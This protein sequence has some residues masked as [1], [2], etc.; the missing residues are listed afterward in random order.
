MRWTT[1]LRLRLRSIFR[2]GRVEDEL[3]EELE[4]HL[5]RL[6]DDYVAGG[7]TPAEARRAARREM[8]G[9]EQRKEECRDARGLTFVNA[10]RQDVAYAL[11]TFR[12]TPAFTAVA[13]LSLALGIGAN[14][15]IFALWNGILHASL[16]AVHEPGELVML[17]NPDDQGGWTGSLEGP[18]S[19][20]TYQEFEELR[21]NAG[22]FSAMMA[23]QST[24]SDWQVRFEGGAPEETL[25]RLVSGEYF[26]VL[27][28]QPAIGRFFTASDDRAAMPYAVISHSYW[29]R[30]FGGRAD[31]IGTSFTLRK[32]SLT[33]V[34][35]APHGFIGETIGQYPDVWLPMRMQPIVLPGRDRLRDTPPEKSMWLQVFGRLK[36]GVS[37]PQAEAQANAV[38]QAH[39]ESFYGA[40]LNERRRELLDQRLV[41]RSGTQGASSTR[42]EFSLSLTALL[43]AVGLL[44]LIACANLANLLLARGTA[45][46]SEMALRLSLGASRGRLIRQLVTESMVL[47]VAGGAA[48]IL[49]AYVAHGALVR[50]I[51]ESDSDFRMTFALDPVM[52]AFVVAVTLGAAL[53]FGILPAWQ[54]TGSDPAAGLKEQTR[55]AVGTRRQMRSGR[56]LVSL[57]LALSLPLLVGAGLLARTVYNLQHAD[58]GF[59]TDNLLVVRVDV[60]EGAGRVG[61]LRELVEAIR[62]TPGVSAVSFSQLGMFTGGE[63]LATIAVEGFTPR[64]EE[65]RDSA[66]EIIGPKYF[67]TLGVPITLGRE[68]V[69]RDLGGGAPVCVINE[70]FAKR[71]FDRRNPIG[72]R[73]TPV[74]EE[75]RRS[76]QVVGVAKNARTQSLRED[77]EPR[78]FTPAQ[79]PW[80]STSSP[81][82]L[83]RTASEGSRRIEDVRRAILG[84]NGS[85]SMMSARSMDD[86]MAPST[87]QDR[88]TAW[89]AIAFGAVA[90][91]LA[92]FGLYGVLSYGVARRTAEIA[93]RIALG[94]QPARVISMILGE[95]VGLVAVGLVAGGALAY[96]TTRLIGSRLY[97]IAAQDPSTLAV[98]T[99]L[100]LLVALTATYL[101]ARRASRVD[102]LVALRQ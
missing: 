46:R 73:I 3:A 86:Q 31:M 91:L 68:I 2:F 40:A 4:Y 13:V 59:P 77:V 49:V 90:L 33:I 43:A 29:Q 88:T 15:A 6:V 93:V 11:R 83:I 28:V 30:R 78:Y 57:Q 89:L 38:F 102:P 18:R 70:A 87:A 26:Q 10:T 19:W 48:A 95:I 27:G 44:L 56:L 8:G 54:A 55:S 101:P 96:L 81:T 21:D 65:D 9:V 79:E 69:E 32:A 92:A 99:A 7:M 37:W 63:S 100:L 66:T 75:D 80:S 97:G 85:L 35:V 72:L 53:A 36:R 42:H 12:R 50:M 5:E 16:P 34:G 52:L 25:G 45:R 71:F 14:T 23:S 41:L 58:L 64:G 82:F 22:H 39:L 1:T 76:F 47:A 60:R 98:A 84:V 17:T 94:A 62:H 67:S 20:L 74:N 61:L 24:L 51:A